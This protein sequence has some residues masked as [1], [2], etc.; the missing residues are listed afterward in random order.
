TVT[1]AAEAELSTIDYAAEAAKTTDPLWTEISSTEWTADF[2]DNKYDSDFKNFSEVRDKPRTS[3]GGWLREKTITTVITTTTGQKDFY[4]FSLKA[5]YGIDIDFIE[6]ADTPEINIESVGDIILNGNLNAATD[7]D[8]N[9]VANGT[10]SVVSSAGSITQVQAAFISAVETNIRSFNSQVVQIQG[11]I[12][13]PA[14]SPASLSI[15]S[16]SPLSGTFGINASGSGT[17]TVVNTEVFGIGDITVNVVSGSQNSSIS[18]IR[19]VAHGG[20]VLLAAADGIHAFD[21]NSVIQGNR[22]E[23]FTKRTGVG[24]ADQFLQIDSDYVDSNLLAGL[25]PAEIEAFNLDIG[26]GGVTATVKALPGEASGSG[27]AAI[28]GIYIRELAGDMILVNP[29]DLPQLEVFADSAI[30]FNASISSINGNIELQTVDGDIL[31]GSFDLFRTAEAFDENSLT[32]TQ[33]QLLDDGVFTLDAMKYPLSPG[34][35]SVLFPHAEFLGTTPNT[36]PLEN[37]NIVGKSVTLIAGGLSGNDVGIVSDKVGINLTGDF[38]DLDLIHKQILSTASADDVIGVT[39]Q[40]L[41]FVGGNATDLDLKLEDYADGSRWQIINAISTGVDDQ[42]ANPQTLAT[43]ASAHVLVQYDEDSYGLYKYKGS[44]ANVDLAEQDYGNSALWEKIQVGVATAGAPVYGTD[45]VTPV[46]V[47]PN[48]TLVEYGKNVYKYTGSD[49]IT[50]ALENIDY[51]NDPDWVVEI[52]DVF[53]QDASQNKFV[54]GLAGVVDLIEKETMVADGTTVYSYRGPE[55][56]G[57]LATVVFSEPDWV[58]VESDADVF[59]AN[60]GADMYRSS[61]QSVDINTGDFVY[62]KFQ[63]I[64]LTLQLF[65]DVDIEAETSLTVDAGGDVIL[66]TTTDFIIDHIRAGGDV[67]LQAGGSILDLGSNATSAIGTFGQLTLLAGVDVQHVDGSGDLRIQILAEQKLT[68]NVPGNFRVDQVPGSLTIA[69]SFDPEGVNLVDPAGV[70][71][72]I[73]F[74]NLTEISEGTNTIDDLFAARIT[75][76]GEID[77]EVVGG[78]LLVGLLTSDD[79]VVLKASGS[80]L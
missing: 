48:S 78:D 49:P 51:A 25:T 10:V 12:G 9:V 5:D 76:G 50:V 68:A 14:T 44:V 6:G 67:H 3:G 37:P 22:I 58:V 71:P 74:D 30:T 65:D 38:E 79:S 64:D 36:S 80:I 33:Q 23:L 63:V 73:T 15:D 35:V 62:N 18:V 54:N 70:L 13:L 61:Y 53:A 47:T 2:T 57:D 43:D 72:D 46:I 11:G 52:A 24:D 59:V 27:T 29:V 4:T 19:A 39:Y 75:A 28:E 16:Q 66:D 55:A 8:N 31:D 40:L 26:Q 41:K 77:I 42:L 69:L 1:P 56:T 7:E 20:N 45:D 21:E 32:E 17:P 34:L 60:P